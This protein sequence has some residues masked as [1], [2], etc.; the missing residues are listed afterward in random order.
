MTPLNDEI[1]SL[2]KSIERQGVLKHLIIIGS[3][4]TLFY[5]DYFKNQDFHPVIRTTDIDFLIPKKPPQNLK[6]DLSATF[7]EMGF[8]EEFT[9]DGWIKFERPDLHIE[10]LCP[11]LGP[12]SDKPKSIPQLGINARPLRFMSLVA[13]NTIPC[14]FRGIKIV[15]P[16]PAVFSL[17]KLIIS[18]RRTKNVKREN[19]RQQAEAVLTAMTN[20]K[21]ISLLTQTYHRLSKKEKNYIAQAIEKKPL[22]QEMFPDLKK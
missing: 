18:C 7:R 15:I 5:Q 11:R 13:H 4:V 8:S 16:H 10:F 9:Q 14:T 1:Y 22:L 2:L 12:Q 21:D 17:H 19:D 6:T 20:P 3:W